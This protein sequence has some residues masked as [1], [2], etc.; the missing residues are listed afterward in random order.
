MKLTQTLSAM[1][2]LF[3]G[4]TAIPITELMGDSEKLAQVVRRYTPPTPLYADNETASDVSN[5]LK[6]LN[7]QAD[8]DPLVIKSL[9]AFDATYI[10]LTGENEDLHSLMPWAGTHY[11]VGPQAF[12]DTFTRVGLYWTRGPFDLETIFT[13]GA[14]NVTAW[15]SFEIT[16][17]TMK[18]TV[19]SPFSCRAEFNAAGLITYFNYMEDTFATA[20]TFYSGGSKEFCANPFGGCVSI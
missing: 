8:P 5:F 19:T 1:C 7:V 4:A 11:R 20:S 12:I 17:N 10:S 13:D 3:M 6:I 16:S 18:R 9:V 15:G 2:C 14:G